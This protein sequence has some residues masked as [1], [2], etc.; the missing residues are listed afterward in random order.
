MLWWTLRQLRSENFETRER[1][2][3]KLGE[4]RSPKAVESLANSLSTPGSRYFIPNELIESVLI[5]IGMAL[6]GDA[7]VTEPIVAILQHNDSNIR[8]AAARI[9]DAVGWQP[10]DKQRSAWRAIALDKWSE[11][12]GLEQM[13]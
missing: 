3:R 11:V 9:L 13:Q 2:V 5:Q 1:A 12:G 6:H 8:K 10:E 7:R 4:S